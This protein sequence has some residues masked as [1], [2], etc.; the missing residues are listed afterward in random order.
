MAAAVSKNVHICS[1]WP[2]HGASPPLSLPSQEH[3]HLKE[4]NEE[5]ASSLLGPLRWATLTVWT[6]RTLGVSN[7]LSSP[8]HR[9]DSAQLALIMKTKSAA[10]SRDATS[11][12]LCVHFSSFSYWWAS[13]PAISKNW[14]CSISL[15][16]MQPRKQSADNE[17]VYIPTASQGTEWILQNANKSIQKYVSRQSYKKDRYTLSGEESIT[18]A[19]EQRGTCPTSEI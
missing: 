7:C 13:P 5:L 10:H 16:K 14:I 6:P 4:R 12:M 18:S 2:H 11:A 1:C 8:F 9:D 15:W 19:S 17:K 3:K